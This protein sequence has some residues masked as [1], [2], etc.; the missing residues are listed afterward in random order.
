MARKSKW[1]EMV[2]LGLI[3]PKSDYGWNFCVCN[4]LLSESHVN[5]CEKLRIKAE[6]KTIKLA[7]ERAESEVV[8]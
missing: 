4:K 3:L 6:N 7:K 1:Q 5:N 8:A 2:E